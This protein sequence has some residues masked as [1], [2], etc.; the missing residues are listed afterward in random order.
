MLYFTHEFLKEYMYACKYLFLLYYHKNIFIIHYTFLYKNILNKGP[1]Q[2]RKKET[3]QIITT[4]PPKG[5]TTQLNTNQFLS[6]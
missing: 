1:E 2:I 3:I 5:L 6:K 4:T